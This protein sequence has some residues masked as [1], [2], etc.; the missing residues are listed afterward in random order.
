MS[1]PLV[2]IAASTPQTIAV[3]IAATFVAGW[4]LYVLVNTRRRGP[5]APP[6]GAEIE[7][8]PNRRRYF[9]DD[10]LE[11]S[12]LER[13]LGWALLFLVVSAVGPIV[14]WLNEPSRQAGAVEEFD[15]KAVERG[16]Q[17]FLPTDSP[18]HGAHFG[19]AQCHGAKGEGGVTPPFAITDYLG[20]TRQVVWQAPPLDTVRLRYPKPEGNQPDQVAEIITFGRKNTPMPAW[21]V[22]GGGPM[23]A[24]QVTDLVA[25]I[26]SL[27]ITSEQARERAQREAIAEAKRLG[28][29]ASDDSLA[30]D[31]EALFNT[32]CARCHTAGWSYGEPSVPGGGAFGFNLTNGLTLR[33]FPDFDKHVE[34]V[35]KGSI[36]HQEYGVRG[37]GTGRMPGFANLLTEEQIRAIVE[38]ERSL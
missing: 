13:Y 9:A 1:L 32:N 5:D 23:N 12:R 24:Q 10:E 4:L 22:E 36:A 27:T 26:D 34:F 17:L 30:T 33:Q 20:R 31:G 37:V 15:A 21:G 8:A 16:R 18:E 25:Y 35:S 11:G 2:V 38:Y 19:C 3:F 28:G 14:Y 29:T 7:L 6:V